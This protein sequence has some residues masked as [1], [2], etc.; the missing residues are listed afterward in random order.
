MPA[1]LIATDCIPIEA[2]SGK[3]I[4]DEPT[5]PPRLLW[6]RMLLLSLVLRLAVIALTW[7]RGSP[8]G[9][10]AQASELGV[11]AESLRSGQGFSNPFGPLTGPSAFLAPGYPA[12][13]AAVFALFRPFSLTSAVAITLLQALFAAATTV[14]LMRIGHRLFGVR[15]A[16][17]AGAFWAVS[18]AL[19]WLPTIFWE[20]SLSI[21][22]LTALLVLALR[23]SDAPSR[24]S[25]LLLG[26]VGAIALLVNSS[27][28]TVALS[29][30]GWALWCNRRR[31]LT[32]PL[33]GLALFLALS[34][35]WPLRNL[36][37]LHA[38]IPLRSNLGY[39]LWQGNRPGA[40][41]FFLVDLH[42]NT[43]AAERGHWQQLGEV[44]YM[45]EKS[46][47]AKAAIMAN[48]SRFAALTVKRFL[49]FWTGVNRTSAWIAVTH[50]VVTTLFGLWGAVWM[51]RMRRQD[52]A[53][54]LLPLL[55][56]PLPYYITHPDFR[57]RLVLDP[58]LILLGAFA[59]SCR[60]SPLPAGR[61]LRDV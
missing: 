6:K 55:L 24:S 18:P 27:L 5:Y 38:W 33:L 3:N 49:C 12:I 50:I 59:V 60:M 23:C 48:P 52:T 21:L 45:Q 8:R 39:E 17:L 10:F 47:L 4:I 16:N 41:G 37:V 53:L 35:V 25:W 32:A 43:S 1:D 29:C 57:F 14:L 9:F 7:S 13:I 42:P 28:I 61:S 26:G 30:F 58:I 36:R 22:L 34:S 44:R 40:D 31:S 15:A 56:F 20:T 19:L 11:L 46:A 54:L 2:R 51:V